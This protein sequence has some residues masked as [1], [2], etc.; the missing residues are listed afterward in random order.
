MRR[1]EHQAFAERLDC[2]ITAVEQSSYYE[3]YDRGWSQEEALRRVGQA[4]KSIRIIPEINAPVRA[5]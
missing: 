3:G 5:K 1:Q 4:C 2:A